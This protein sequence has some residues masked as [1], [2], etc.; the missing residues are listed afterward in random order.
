MIRENN[1][2][3][4]ESKGRTV[5]EA[6]DEALLELGARR[7][8]VEIEVLEEGKEGL[9]GMIGRR[10]ARVLVT[11][12]AKRRRPRRRSGRGRGRSG[13][14][15]SGGGRE[16][17]SASRSGGDE[18]RRDGSAGGAR[19]DD[20]RGGR[21]D[22]SRGGRRDDSRGGRRDDS[23][24]GRR[25]D[26][27]GEQGQTR[28]SG[29]ERSRDR[30]GSGDR[31]RRPR[32]EAASTQS[33]TPRG[34]QRP[35]SIDSD[36]GRRPEPGERTVEATE[37]AS[38]VPVSG[39]APVAETRP[40]TAAASVS[41][42]VKASDLARPITGFESGSVAAAQEKFSSDLMRL[43]GFPCRCNV[44]ED[45]YNLVKIVTDEPSASIL[46]GRNG[47][48]ISAL[49]TL[50]ERLTSQAT[51]GPVHMNLDINNYRRRREHR[52]AGLTRLSMQKVRTNGQIEHLPPLNARER[53][54]V[55]MT[56]AESD[57]LSTTTEGFG[58]D[59]HVVILPEGVSEADYAEPSDVP[60]VAAE[61]PANAGAETTTDA[62][63]ADPGNEKR[64]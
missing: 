61:A 44:V 8:E 36:P 10:S 11:P 2:E 59:R 45:E 3:P 51:G 35:R 15:D 42:T 16:G 32:E 14:D 25:D 62:A 1:G 21:R 18:D 33:G 55:H 17:A 54:I 37:A 12:K 58:L 48:A 56:V 34:E 4:I 23:R 5:Q 13:S 28:D 60:G 19:R 46:V 53:R 57:D 39:T 26:S 27:R 49:E 50:V 31:T 41:A 38:A 47:H 63:E 9:F 64:D 24:G 22:D 29:G 20:G 6:I 7:N 52:L 40:E 43:C 30:A